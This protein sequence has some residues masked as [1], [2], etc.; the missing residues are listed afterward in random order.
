M[1]RVVDEWCYECLMKQAAT[2]FSYSQTKNPTDMV[3]NGLS[4]AECKAIRNQR[5]SRCHEIL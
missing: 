2:M 5:I 1:I 3:S 4:A